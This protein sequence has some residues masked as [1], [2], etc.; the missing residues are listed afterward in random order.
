[1]GKA[2]GAHDPGKC[3]G[4]EPAAADVEEQG[5]E[6]IQGLREGETRETSPSVFT[7]D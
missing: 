6:P 1:M 7:R 4:P 5:I 2:H 3:L